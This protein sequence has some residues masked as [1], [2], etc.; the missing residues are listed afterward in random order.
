MKALVPSLLAVLIAGAALAQEAE[1]Q[2]QDEAGAAAEGTDTEEAEESAED[3]APEP[4]A[5]PS[6]PTSYN[7]SGAYA[8]PPTSYNPTGA[9]APSSPALDPQTRLPP[10]SY[11]P[12]GA[13]S[14]SWSQPEW[15]QPS[16][17]V[18]LDQPGRTGAPPS[19]ADAAYESRLRSSFLSAQGMKGPLEGGWV[20]TEPGGGSLYHLQLV[21]SA[22]G[23]IEGAW[24]DLRRPGAINASG[25]IVNA[26][27]TGGLLNL[28]FYPE[29][30][31][32]AVTATLT[33][34]ADGGWSGELI[35]GGRRQS[36]VL[37]RQY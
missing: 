1:P 2:P 29:G 18:F 30:Q 36:V 6:A 24:R 14:P 32:D 5:L 17:P 15:T 4:A 19:Y 23:F 22:G 7:P 8:A 9:Y 21:D 25:L 20:I 34:T 26:M 10:T 11:N 16:T 28:R 13:Y 27:R 31:R 3:A 37:K 33:A 35:E 12:S